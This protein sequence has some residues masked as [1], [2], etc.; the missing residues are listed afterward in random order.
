MNVSLGPCRRSE[1]SVC[2]CVTS[3]HRWALGGVQPSLSRSHVWRIWRIRR[4]KAPLALRP[5]AFPV[6]RFFLQRN[7]TP[8]LR[9]AKGDSRSRPPPRRQNTEPALTD[10]SGCCSD[11]KCGRGGGR[12]GAGASPGAHCTGGLLLPLGASKL[13]LKVNSM[14]KRGFRWCLPSQP[15]PHH[16]KSMVNTNNGGLSTPRHILRSGDVP[17]A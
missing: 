15:P 8:R 12:G 3:D 10:P 14:Y 7:L 13:C 4:F 6:W 16:M 1:G 2:T 5:P 9:T 11:Y 17:A